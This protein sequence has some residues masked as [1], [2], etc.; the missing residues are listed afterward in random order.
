[1]RDDPKVAA[2]TRSVGIYFARIVAVLPQVLDRVAPA[3][4]VMRMTNSP[5]WISP[6]GVNPSLR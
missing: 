3:Y 4:N 6:V 2:W 5:S 1:M